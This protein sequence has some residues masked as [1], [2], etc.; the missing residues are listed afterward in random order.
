MPPLECKRKQI[1]DAAIAEFQQRG[2]QGAN[3]DR[4]AA[5]AEVSKRT[6]YNHFESKEALFRSIADRARDQVREA[7][8][9][10]YD[11]DKPLRPQLLELGR[12]EGQLLRSDD[13]M[14]MMRMGTS[15]LLRDPDLAR[16]LNLPSVHE[17]IFGSFFHAAAESGTLRADD[18]DRVAKQFLGMIK[19]QAFW[20]A[21]FS[22][23]LVAE[24]EID[25]IVEAS[26]DTIVSAYGAEDKNA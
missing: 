13:F 1:I 19:A 20:P 11:S 26:V 6:V 17:G 9:V 15:E 23:T 22:G 2:F 21:V 25:R 12:A 10:T 8:Q 4:I 16:R 3:M 5:C 14:S 24:E 7:I 18:P